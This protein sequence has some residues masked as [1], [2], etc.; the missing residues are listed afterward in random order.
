[1]TG[2]ANKYEALL[3]SVAC[4]LCGSNDFTV[5]YPPRYDIARPEG[6]TN[7][8]KSSGDEILFD[9]LVRCKICGLQYLNPRLRE[10]LILEGYGSGTDERFVSQL[11]AREYTYEKYLN[12]IERAQKQKGRI[13]DVGTAGGSFLGVA[14]RRGWEVDGCEPSNWL[15]DWCE[16]HYNIKIHP[17]TVFDA[18]Q[19][20]GSFDVVTLWDVLEHTTDPK[21]VLEECHRI[22]KPNGLLVVS[23]PDIESLVARL[24]GRKWVFLL[25]VHLYY[26]TLSTIRKMLELTGFEMIDRCNYWNNLQLNYILSRMEPYF[27][28]VARAGMKVT[29]GLHMENI[30]IP[31]WMGQIMVLARKTDI[32]PEG[33]AK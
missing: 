20:A 4:N 19:V 13:F 29:K 23:Y 7:S 28:P 17:G 32:A 22:L 31:Y 25:S 24:M 2:G 27:P 6:I 12:V 16:R 11:S 9:Q 33:A 3:E 5:I 1:M 15:C 10:N 14:K 26:F 8:F 18:K 21:S 30:Q